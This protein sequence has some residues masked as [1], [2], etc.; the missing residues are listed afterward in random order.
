MP[1]ISPQDNNILAFGRRDGLMV[2]ALCSE[3]ND[4]GSI[5]GRGA[6]LCS[7]A[8]HFTLIV[9]LSTE[10]YKWVLPNLLLQGVTLKWAIPST[11]GGSSNKPSCLILRK[12]G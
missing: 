3:S 11:A 4:P 9:S 2:S 6:A 8:R 5:P 10:V 7:W 12:L 1:L